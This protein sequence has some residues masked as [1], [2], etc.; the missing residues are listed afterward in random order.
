MHGEKLNQEEGKKHCYALC[1]LILLIDFRDNNPDNTNTN[2][3]DY[4]TND[5]NTNNDN[6]NDN[7]TI[8]NVTSGISSNVNSGV[9]SSSSSYK[10]KIWPNSRCNE[11]AILLG[12]N[13]ILLWRSKLEFLAHLGET[14]I[15][16]LLLSFVFFQLNDDFAGVQSRLG[17]LF[18]AS[19]TMIIST[20]NPLLSVFAVDRAIL[21]RER[22]GAT[23][24]VLP[25]FAAKFLSLIP[26]SMLLVTIFGTPIYFITGLTMPFSRFLV[27]MAVLASLRLASIA[28][29]LFV[30]SICSTVKVSLT[31]GG[32][33]IAV[34]IIF[35]GYLANPEDI[36]WIL[37]W[38]QYI[39]LQYYGFQALAQNELNGNY[40][41]VQGDSPD[42]VPGS[43]YLNLYSLNQINEWGCVG[44]I[45]GIGLAFLILGYAGLRYSTRPKLTL[46][47]KNNS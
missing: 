40:F 5:Y 2:T 22:A 9:S 27:Y 18:T 19:L 10:R 24:R 23:Y 44:A 39:S 26:L 21:L 43:Y 33:I 47:I 28:L 11:M 12:R 15:V 29:G 31:I 1:Y 20:V 37:R 4:N 6:D 38:I 16:C 35:G 14:L 32:M 7:N 41:G 42:L 30:A 46:K 25:S 36:T 45:L 13:F 8:I 34:F 3:N 17:L